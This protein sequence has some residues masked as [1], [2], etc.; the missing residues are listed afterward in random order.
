MR[1]RSPSVSSEEEGPTYSP[2]MS[3]EEEPE[4]VYTPSRATTSRRILPTLPTPVRVTPSVTQEESDDEQPG[5]V[6]TRGGIDYYYLYPSGRQVTRE[7]YERRVAAGAREYERRSPRRRS[8]SPVVRR[9]QSRSR[10]PDDRASRPTPV[11][12][13]EEEERYDEEPRATI[14]RDGDEYFYL[15]PSGDEITREEYELRMAARMPEEGDT[16]PER[17]SP[18]RRSPSPSRRSPSPRRRSPSPVARESRFASRF[19]PVVARPVREAA[20]PAQQ[21]RVVPRTV[22][23]DPD[24]LQRM[25][26]LQG[27]TIAVPQG[28]GTYARGT[29]TTPPRRAEA[30][31]YVRDYRAEEKQRNKQGLP[32]F[33]PPLFGE[34]A[35][36]PPEL[37]NEPYSFFD[38][39]LRPEIVKK[40]EKFLFEIIPSE[41]DPTHPTVRCSIGSKTIARFGYADSLP[42]KMSSNFSVASAYDTYGLKGAYTFLK[43]LYYNKYDDDTPLWLSIYL[44]GSL[45]ALRPDFKPSKDED[46][47]YY[48]IYLCSQIMLELVALD[49]KEPRML[50]ELTAPEDEEEMPLPPDILARI[51]GGERVSK[52]LALKARVQVEA[53]KC[54][55]VPS[56]DDLWQVGGEDGEG[57]TIRRTTDNA[58]FNLTRSG[59]WLLTRSGDIFTLVL[60]ARTRA[61]QLPP[62]YAKIS[63]YPLRDYETVFE[64]RRCDVNQAMTNTLTSVLQRLATITEDNLQEACAWIV[65]LSADTDAGQEGKFVGLD[66]IGD[67]VHRLLQVAI[68]RYR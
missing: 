31:T 46:S 17:P 18:R 11:R 66:E 42:D 57:R 12:A 23:T 52:S 28:T 62:Q 29:R 34:L 15:H 43:H 30:S 37:A 22:A 59:E 1:L 58:Y 33:I 60:E 36:L 35:S 21:Q 64:K 49:M 51:I 13:T 27:A 24:M 68:A 38:D 2:S 3:S 39:G 63:E 50:G 61:R 25:T 16:S 53:T 9:A 32:D 48:I 8:P 54:A 55:D 6:R 4:P 7:E 56:E 20:A 45:I 67:E 44:Q 19:P 5:A 41:D 65:Q 26:A 40:R 14:T 47:E 10:S